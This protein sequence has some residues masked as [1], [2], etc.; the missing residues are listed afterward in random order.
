M[1]NQRL[2]DTVELR[3]HPARRSVP[4]VTWKRAADTMGKLVG[5]VIIRAIGTI[6]SEVLRALSSSGGCLW[7]AFRDQVA[8]GESIEALLR[9]GP[10][11]QRCGLT[12]ESVCVIIHTQRRAVRCG[13]SS[14]FMKRTT[15]WKN[16]WLTAIS[17]SNSRIFLFLNLSAHTRLLSAKYVLVWTYV[18]DQVVDNKILLT[19][20]LRKNQIYSLDNHIKTHNV[21][22]IVEWPIAT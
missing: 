7:S 15:T 10:A 8:V 19:T 14:S 3:E 16:R 17:W 12:E 13:C 21:C 5:M 1:M 18:L 2:G 11:P 6:R 4:S 20:E 9:Y 22:Y